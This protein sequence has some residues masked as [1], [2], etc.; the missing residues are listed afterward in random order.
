MSSHLI[1]VLGRSVG[2]GT[3]YRTASYRFPDGSR[4]HGAFFGL[5][6]Y[7][8]L[9]GVEKAGPDRLLF[10]GTPTSMWDV[11]TEKLGVD[12]TL[13]EKIAERAWDGGVSPALLRSLEQAINALPKKEGRP[14]RVD[15]RLIPLGRNSEEQADIL[16][17][18]T[19]EIGVG[20]QVWLDVT[21]GF[22]HLAMLGLMA[23]LLLREERSAQVRNVYYGALDMTP[24]DGDTPVIPLEGLMGIA[25]WLSALARYD[26]GG[27]YGVFAGLLE[28]DGVVAAITRR[29]DDATFQERSFQA[30]EV[31]KSLQSVKAALSN[32]AAGSISRLFRKR[33]LRELSWTDPTGPIDLQ[34][35]LAE[36][37]RRLGLWVEALTAAMEALITTQVLAEGGDPALRDDR[38][39]VDLRGA[40]RQLR[41]LR[42]ALVHETTDATHPQALQLLGSRQRFAREFG[43]LWRQA[44]P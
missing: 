38:T 8:W 29:L 30:K 6:L 4:R 5:L 20:D 13:Y 31:R 1:S 17:T 28:K 39:A 12:D 16:A 22:R 42:N 14:R 35:A 3:S 40:A 25:D 37:A 10:L 2:P 34:W 24:P 15:L 21:H 19:R 44:R 43:K 27:D 11:L 32:L 18:M 26:G 23:A 36:R 33:L 9:C 7:D 41:S